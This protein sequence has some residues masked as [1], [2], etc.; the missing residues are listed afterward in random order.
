ME[1]AFFVSVRDAWLAYRRWLA[2]W[3]DG[4]MKILPT[5]K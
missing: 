2:G 4:G 3:C 1:C 5:R